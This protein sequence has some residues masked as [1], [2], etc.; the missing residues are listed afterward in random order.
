MSVDRIVDFLRNTV[1]GRILQTEE[2]AYAL[3][4]GKLEGVYSDRMSFANVVATGAGLQFD[5]LVNASEKL[6]QLDEKR[7][8]R[9]L[10]KDFS[11]SSRFHYELTERKSSGEI[12]GHM[13]FVSST[14]ANPPAE[15]VASQVYQVCFAESPLSWTEKEILYRDQPSVGDA[16]KA[17]AFEAQCCLSVENGLVAYRY[18][19]V[20]FDVDTLSLERTPSQ[21]IYPRF[22][23]REMQPL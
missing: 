4:D 3:E 1:A 13:R 21:A 6:Y 7:K 2:L 19:G 11:S 18:D 16:Y 9:S 12:T 14:M 8:R 23:A 15:A 20:C 22:L 10:R 17:V 5:L